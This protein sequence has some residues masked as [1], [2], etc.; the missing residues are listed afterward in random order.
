[1]AQVFRD[2][3][4]KKAD[5]YGMLFEQ[6][7]KTVEGIKAL[8]DYMETGDKT[9]ADQVREIESMADLKRR[10][11]LDE[12]EKMFITP[13][14]REDIYL[15]SKAI[16]DIIDYGERTVEEMEAFALD[17]KEELDKMVE[18]ILEMARN[19]SFAVKYLENNRNILKNML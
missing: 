8:S 6:S 17:N 16:D 10:I 19:I 5:F 12:L 4:H 13:F 1:M 9:F 2:S 3:L 18:I 11:L 7:Q 14:E 15:L